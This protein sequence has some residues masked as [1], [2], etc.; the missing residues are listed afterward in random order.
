M[1]FIYKASRYNFVKEDKKGGG[2][3]IYNTKTGAID[4]VEPESVEKFDAILLKS[5]S[6]FVE[7]DELYEIMYQQGYIVRQEKDE[8]QDIIDWNKTSSEVEHITYLT[9]LPTETC[10]FA[11]P[12]CFIYT[13]RDRHMT[14]ETWEALYKYCVKFFEKNKEK[15]WFQIDLSWFGGEPLIVADKIMQFMER[16]K[17]LMLQYPNARMNS[18]IVT[19]G[20]LLTYELF[21]KMLDLGIR[22]W[23]VTLDGDAETH[24]TLRTTQGKKPTFDVIYKNLLDIL[25][26]VP[27]NEEFSFAIRGNFLRSTI[28]SCERLLNKYRQDFSHDKRFHIYFRPVY[29]FD[30]DRN[31][32]DAID[33]D[34]LECE[35]G[36]RVQNRLSM[37][38][39]N[40]NHDPNTLVRVTNPLPEPT[41]SWC[42]SIKKNAHIIGYDGSVFSCD[43]MIT[44]KKDAVGELKPD[45]SIVLNDNAKIWKQS[46]FDSR[47]RWGD[48]LDQCL[49]C[50][51]L[52]VCVGGCNR[53][54]IVNGKNPCFWNDNLIYD[55]MDEY[56]D[57]YQ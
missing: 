52:P 56:A 29:N 28:T 24:D 10:N 20:Y 53:S 16:I 37:D 55:A 35:E 30:T 27:A 13:F 26:N 49:A 15:K 9:I 11:C 44:E 45:G 33:A 36:V 23:Q 25:E 42:T 46:I 18:N 34:I 39:F 1:S 50:R 32:I 21:K 7:N 22:R 40:I 57:S 48:M 4:I 14:D 43:T 31:D 5:D 19:N 12:Y 54:R 41:H 6:E 3:I 8:V 51:L 38:S 47:D 17:E 2:K